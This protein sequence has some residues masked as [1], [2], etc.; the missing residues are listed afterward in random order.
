VRH[1][2][3]KSIALPAA[4]AILVALAGCGGSDQST[5][6]GAQTTDPIGK[7]GSTQKSAPTKHKA[8]EKDKGKQK[9]QTPAK[10]KQKQVEKKFRELAESGKPIPADSPVAKQIIESLTGNEGSGKKGKKGKNSVAKAIEQVV[11]P[12]KNGGGGSSPSGQ[13][14]PSAGVE[15]ILEQIQKK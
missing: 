3:L 7:G 5:T 13:D 10:T 2:N 12:P 9:K 15:E 6:T 14:A 4:I 8:A 1:L 11:S